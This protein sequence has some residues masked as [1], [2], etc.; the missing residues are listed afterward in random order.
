MAYF[1]RHLVPTVPLLLLVA[2]RPAAQE[3][4][5]GFGNR[6]SHA[7]RARAAHKANLERHKGAKDVLVLPGLVANRKVKRVEIM[8]EATGMDVGAIVEFLLIDQSSN[9]GYEALLWSYAKPSDIHKALVFIGMQPG[10]P[11]NPAKLRSWPKGERVI[12]TVTGE[13]PGESL[14]LE[15]MVRDETRDETLPEDGFVFTGSYTV[16]RRGDRERRDYAADVT[17]ARSVAS[18]FS[19]PTAVLDVPRPVL[20]GAVYGKLVVNSEYDFAANQLVTIVLEPEYKDG[21]LR[22]KD[23]V[24]HVRPPSANDQATGSPK[25]G[26]PLFVLTDAKGKTL[27]EKPSLPAALAA[28]DVLARKGHDACVSIRFDAG[29]RLADV[30]TVCRILAVID[31]MGGV[32]IEPPAKGQLYYKAFLPSS[33]LLDRQ[34]RVAQ[35]WE[36]R[37]VRQGG[38]IT[39]RLAWYDLVYADDKPDPELKITRFDVI[40][41]EALRGRLDAA[42]ERRKRAG[43]PPHTRAIM[44]FAEGELAY[45]RLVE[46]LGPALATHKAVHV[47][48]DVPDAP[49]AKKR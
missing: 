41:P 3:D 6:P 4:P 14:R 23:L 38:A 39:G 25:G 30:R 5:D 27:T 34:K 48:L 18:I 49:D 19:D 10:V 8:A 1:T 7:E 44:V 24:L 16:P 42:A 15:K 29:L 2:A 21:R 33:R 46:F 40:T 22:V 11:Y 32:R 9:R 12:L 28:L 36:L 20:Q 31:V 37:L 43:K 47:F 45:G 13:G 35:P 26:R 17:G